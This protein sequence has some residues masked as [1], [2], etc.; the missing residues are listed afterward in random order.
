MIKIFDRVGTLAAFLFDSSVSAF[1]ADVSAEKFKSFLPSLST[2]FLMYEPQHEL[3]NLPNAGYME[4]ME[5]F[6]LGYGCIFISKEE[7]LG[8]T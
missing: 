6:D 3:P 8:W 1:Y 2:S 4:L 7:D 5:F